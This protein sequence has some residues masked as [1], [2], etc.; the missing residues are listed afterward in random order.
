MR[1]RLSGWLWFLGKHHFGRRDDWDALRKVI[2]AIQEIQ[3]S[4]LFVKIGCP[5]RDARYASSGFQYL[6]TCAVTL[7]SLNVI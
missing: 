7:D 3:V 5:H 2:R 1:L 4:R 6:D